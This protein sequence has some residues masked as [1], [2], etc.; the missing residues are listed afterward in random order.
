MSLRKIARAWS[1]APPETPSRR[2]DRRRL[3]G[4][5]GL[6]LI[7]LLV[8][9]TVT[10][11]I[12][13]ALTQLFVATSNSQSDQ[14]N[15]IDA[16]QGA[17]V[18]LDRLRREAH[19]AT[20]VTRNSSSSAT[21]TIPP[22][23]FAASLATAITLLPFSP[24]VIG[25]TA[26]FPTGTNTITVGGS[27]TVTCTGLTSTS[28][29]GCTG[30]SGG[31]YA[32]G[33][34]V[35]ST[36]TP[37]KSVTWC[38]T[39]SGPYSLMRYQGSACSGTGTTVLTSLYS[40]AIFPN[41]VVAASGSTTLPAAVSLPTASFTV[42]ASAGFASGANS[43]S[44]GSSSTVSCTLFAS[45]MFSGCTGG[46]GTYSKG[47]RVSLVGQQLANI[48]VSLPVQS[49]STPVRRFTVGD[50]IDLRNSRL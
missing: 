7:E 49:T 32:V 10:L 41:A 48:T 9:S 1:L 4:E 38:T 42:A 19:C 40:N 26:G 50:S 28:F 11:I 14:T 31:P 17:R 20:S 30:G 15:R 47:T 3:A 36:A 24:I 22:A 34:A 33:A 35:I 6:T 21:F 2:L 27:T 37:G 39:G 8:A 18:A 12:L 46:T 23:C 44:I 43:I 13:G 29:T 25:N 45:L 5:D 16:Q